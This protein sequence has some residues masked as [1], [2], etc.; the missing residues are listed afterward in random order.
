MRHSTSVLLAL[1]LLAVAGLAQKD[2][3]PENAGPKMRVAVIDIEFRPG[4]YTHGWN[5]VPAAFNTGLV[6]KIG[7]ALQ[8]T[9]RFVVVERQILDEIRQ[10]QA[11]AAQAGKAGDKPY[12]QPAQ[13]L[14]KAVITEFT[15]AERGAGVGIDIKGLGKVQGRVQEALVRMNLRAIDPFTS[16]V[17]A[18]QSGDG[19]ATAT[20][21]DFSASVS[22]VL[23]N[24]EL[25]NS[26]PLGH[27][28]SKAIDGAVRSLVGEIKDI[29]WACRVIDA[30]GSD[31][32]IN[33][34]E[35]DGLRVGDTLEVMRVTKTVRD[36]ETGEVLGREEG[37]VGLLRVKATRERYSICVVTD[38]EKP[39]VGDSVRMLKAWGDG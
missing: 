22:A 5:Q 37:R 15:Y 27:A 2:K 34:G 24:F 18:S 11:I 17:V 39:V 13:L 20:A 26:S 29:P 21:V 14:I 38:G 7:D 30:E 23:S 31:I 9:G 16:E 10:E 8:K 25:F 32:Y 3:Q 6:E 19:R 36:P 28:T 4:V 1:V 33:A 35:N 12:V